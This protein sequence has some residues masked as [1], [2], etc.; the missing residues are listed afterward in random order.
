MFRCTT[1]D[2]DRIY[3]PWIARSTELL[4]WSDWQPHHALLDLCGGTGV[5]AKEAIAKGAKQP[6]HL[7]D[8][9]PRCD[10]PGVVQ[11]KGDANHVGDYYQPKSFDVVV[12]RQAMAYLNP[13]VFFDSVA[14][15]I[16]P[17]GRLVFNTFANPPPTI[18]F[19]TMMFKGTRFVEAHI[20]MFD[21]IF[22]IQVRLDWPPRMDVSMFRYMDFPN[23]WWSMGCH[24]KVHID[25]QGKSIRVCGI[26]S[27]FPT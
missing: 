19:K 25:R 17:N 24:F 13:D 18:G 10:I 27:G 15:I 21:C 2:Y 7:F 11:T 8:L 22:H 12:C 3:A 5:I 20:N 9:N 1:K 4:N 23:L 26:R 16:K 14:K 6:V